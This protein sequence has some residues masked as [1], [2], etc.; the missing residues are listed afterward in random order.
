[1]AMRPPMPA[2]TL[3]RRSKIA[4]SV[5]GI[6][7]LLIVVFSSLTG[8]YINW[9]WFGEVGFRNVYST[10][11]WTRITL[12]LIFGLL[13]A[14]IIG[15]NLVIAYR[16]RPPFRPMSPEQQNLE[17]DRV[18]LEP[19]KR[20]ILLSLMLLA[21]FS[22][23]MSAQ[24]QWSTWLLWLHGGKF[25]VTDPQ[26]GKD[27]SFYAWDYP[28]YRLMLGFG[29]TAIIFS[30][31]LSIAVHYL[32]GAI[33]LQTP[34]PKIT[35]AARRHLTILVFI[36]MLLKAVAYWLDRYGL[37]FANRTGAFT[38]ASYTDVNATLPAKTILFWIAL[39]I[40][41]AVLA[42]LWLKSPLIPGIAFVAM[43]V[44]SIVISGIYPALLQQVS[45]KP[46]ASDKEQPYIRRN[47]EATRQAYG[48]VTDDGKSGG[49]VSY[50]EY[51]VTTTPSTDALTPSDPTIANVRVLD[52][53]VVSQ[54]F[55]QLQALQNYYGFP[56]KLDVDRYKL[57][58]ITKDYIVGVRE[59]SK[60]RL[61]GDQTNWINQHTNYTH[62]YGFVAA[63]ADQ[64][65]TSAAD[66]AAGGIPPSGPLSAALKVPQV[67]FGELVNDYVIVGAKGTPRE[68]D[69][70]GSA[71][72]TYAGNGG[73]SLGN[74]ITRL[75]FAVQYRQTNFLLNNVASTAGAKVLIN[76]DPRDRL[77]KIA[78]FLKV[79]G[80]PYPIV[81]AATGHIVWMVDA[82]TTMSNYPYSQRQSLSD[83]TTD[84]LTQTNRT[85]GQP[86]S[87][88]N[89]I[90]T[91]VKATVDAYD[92]T[93]RLYQWDANDPVLKAWMKVFPNLVQPRGSMPQSVLDHVRYPEDLFEVQRSLLEQYHVDDPVT[94]YNANDRWTVPGDPYAT[95]DQPP[96]YVLADA[97]TAG[98]SGAQFQL[99]SPMK[100]NQKTN[101]A[102]YITVDSDP[103]ANYGKM[104]VLT[105]PRSFNIDGPEQVANNFQST[106]VISKDITQLDA[107]GSQVVH[108][109][110]LTLP[111]GDTFLYVEPLY[112][113]K[114]GVNGF[115]VLQR[116]L[117]SYGSKIGYADSL[118]KALGDLRPGHSTGET[119][120]AL[121]T[122][123]PADNNPPSS[124]PTPTPSG[125][126]SGPTGSASADQ[127]LVQLNTALNELQAAYKSGDF[128]RIGAAQADVQK[129]LEAYLA[130]TKSSS[131]PSK[132]GS[133]APTPTPSK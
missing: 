12:F 66:Y 47:I 101:L 34:G 35:I 53:N 10:I 83:L 31:L 108:G 7:I 110:L 105:L 71:K 6:L 36:F 54:T 27:I 92:G 59:L 18:M 61:S 95:G 67:Y 46:N 93:V 51:N 115:P 50:R 124:S 48:I 133:S 80:D 17:R 114:S 131:A 128:A 16:L 123:N 84:S 91:S 94:F 64:D 130:A 60:D 43:L 79:D 102:A 69:G 70:Q 28:A 8:V 56:V 112:V 86:N 14:A 68:F 9:Q 120:T 29:F 49:T 44:L 21:L 103:G 65:V 96:Y 78:P 42:S 75:A 45:V 62:G 118:T 37:V 88:I 52:P 13:M 90:R 33:R 19:R 2:L 129:K 39:L 82:Y 30:L 74:P 20:V 22:A 122:T 38:G 4:L 58:G 25:G 111:I 23:G 32:S 72:V 113:Q 106:P 1:M 121:G 89:Y 85:V 73:I 63:A 104:T 57:D 127:L 41:A 132:S 81:D 107:G 98:D 119:L 15:A 26:F 116:I 109:N 55:I 126:S 5:V 97:Q 100:R 3:S 77:K 125:S 87:Q 76:R 11:L 40:A 24:S 99:T 117:V